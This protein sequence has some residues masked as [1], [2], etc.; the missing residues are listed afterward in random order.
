MFEGIKHE[1]KATCR[2]LGRGQ[3]TKSSDCLQEQ[4][5][6]VCQPAPKPV[7]VCFDVHKLHIKTMVHFKTKLKTVLRPEVK[8]HE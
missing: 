8:P 5:T 7:D 1:T 2:T 6:N 4:T 3:K